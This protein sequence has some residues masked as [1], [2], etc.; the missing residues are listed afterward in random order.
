MSFFFNGWSSYKLYCKLM[1]VLRETIVLERCITLQLNN[2]HQSV[3]EQVCLPSICDLDYNSSN[4]LGSI[5]MCP[6]ILN[7]F[8]IERTVNR[9]TVDTARLHPFPD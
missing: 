4:P 9:D 8:D 2:Q 3:L 6:G 5:L 7:V 1:L